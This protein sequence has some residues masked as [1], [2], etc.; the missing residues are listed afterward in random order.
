[1][2]RP[3][4]NLC[5][6]R[7]TI[8]LSEELDEAVLELRRT[9]EYCRCSYA[10]IIRVMMTEGAKAIKERLQSGDRKPHRKEQNT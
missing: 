1:M 10:E 7:L 6:K 5:Y 2:A 4:K 9:R 8:Y 3:T